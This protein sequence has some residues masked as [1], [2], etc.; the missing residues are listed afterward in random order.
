MTESTTSEA[1]P[2]NVRA[3]ITNDLADVAQ[4]AAGRENTRSVRYDWEEIEAVNGSLA[5]SLIER[6]KI[7]RDR[8]REALSAWDA[9]DLPNATVRIHNLPE[10]VKYRVG[11][12]RTKDL[13]TAIGIT[14]NV[15]EIKPVE[16]HATVAAFECRRCGTLSNASQGYGRMVFPVACEACESSAKKNWRFIRHLSE[17]QDVREVTLERADTN[18]DDAPPQLLVRLTDDLVDRVGPGDRVSLVGRY[19][20]AQFQNKSILVTF[21]DTWDIENH[22]EG[23]VMDKLPPERINEMIIEEV[24]EQQQRGSEF[25]ADREAVEEAIEESGVRANEVSTRIDD[26]VDGDD[27]NELPGGRLMTP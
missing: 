21:L 7:Y 2:E 11:E 19:D 6:P 16:T 4:Q 13:G 25:S 18:L 10:R 24:S 3:V 20:T 26:L 17:L 5:D 23:T 9:V 12:E 22:Q 1:I 27:L 15:E 14:G 8:I